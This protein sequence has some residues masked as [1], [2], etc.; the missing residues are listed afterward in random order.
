MCGICGTSKEFYE[1]GQ[2]TVEWDCE[3]CGQHIKVTAVAYRT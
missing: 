1:V 2:Y 3:K